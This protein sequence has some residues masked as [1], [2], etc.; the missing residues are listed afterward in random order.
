MRDIFSCIRSI[1]QDILTPNQ[2]KDK[3]VRGSGRKVGHLREPSHGKPLRSPSFGQE[4]RLVLGE[5]EA[6]AVFFSGA[7]VRDLLSPLEEEDG[8]GLASALVKPLHRHRV[9]GVV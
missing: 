6:H 3:H 1:S 9:A 8:E 7:K 2:A 4:H 5:V